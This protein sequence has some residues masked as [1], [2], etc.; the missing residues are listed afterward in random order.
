MARFFVPLS[1]FETSQQT[2]VLIFGREEPSTNLQY[3]PSRSSISHCVFRDWLSM[4][5]QIQE[6]SLLHG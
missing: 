3:N 6:Q 1:V 4:L 2:A 5:L